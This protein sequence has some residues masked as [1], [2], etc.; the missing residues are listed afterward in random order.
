MDKKMML[1][2]LAALVAASGA[3]AGIS[4]PGLLVPDWTGDRVML[5]SSFDGSLINANFITTASGAGFNSPK[6]ALQVGN[7]IYVSDQIADRVFEFDLSGS[8][9]RTLGAGVLDNVRGIEAVNNTLYVTNDG[10]ALANSVVSFDLV[11]GNQTGSFVTGTSPFDVKL[12]NGELL[13]SDSTDDNVVRWSTAGVNLGVLVSPNSGGLQFPQQIATRGNGNL[14]VAGFSPPAGLY[15]YTSV[16]TYLQTLA[17]GL[18]LRGAYELGNGN[19]MVTDGTT[20][21]VLN[22]SQGT[23]T[24]IISGVNAQ[25]INPTSVPTPGGLAVLA[26]M[27]VVVARRRR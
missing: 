23:I 12:R 24:T 1:A 6:E 17:S 11:S 10:G 3:V 5:F 18:G 25:Y 2:G 13:V 27:G 14:L 19:I 15:E 7:R 20:V 21:Q 9:V 16:G 4:P 8:L 26:A 22:P